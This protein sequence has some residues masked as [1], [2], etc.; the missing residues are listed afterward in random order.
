MYLR[1]QCSYNGIPSKLLE[2]CKV[3]LTG[4]FQGCQTVL[5]IFPPEDKNKKYHYDNL[6]SNKMTVYLPCFAMST[7]LEFHFGF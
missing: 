3:Q 2:L 6:K 5:Y 1:F 4:V 7:L